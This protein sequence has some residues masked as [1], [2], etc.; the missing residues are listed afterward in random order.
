MNRKKDL[1]S[2]GEMSKITGAHIKSLRYYEQINIL[3]P[4]FVDPNSGYR[5]YSFD[6]IYLVDFIMFCIELHIPLKELAKLADVDNMVDSRAF[7]QKGREIAETK[8]RAI[9]KGLKFIA[10]I[11]QQMDL[12][13]QN[14]LEQ[15]YSR[16]IAEKFFYL[17]PQG[18]SLANINPLD[19]AKSF[20]E[21]PYYEDDY[22]E[23]PEYGLL[24]EYSPAGMQYYTFMELPKHLAQEDNVRTIP[25]GT[26]YFRYSEDYQI[27]QAA[28]I[29]NDYLAGTDSFLAIETE[30]FTGKHKINK[31]IKELR[32]IAL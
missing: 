1:L 4:A 25:A 31:P 3:K 7:L 8:L 15:I 9:E 29:F 27:N 32:V 13:E 10:K 26:Y 14:K 30:I 12:A 22:S 20:L 2:I 11:E 5:Y 19:L 24:Y 28:E 18:Q 17:K 23:L 16:E 21:M 6:Q